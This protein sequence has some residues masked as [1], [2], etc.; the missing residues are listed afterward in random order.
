M[1]TRAES[2]AAVRAAHGLDKIDPSNWTYD[3]RTHY[4]KALATYILANER[5]DAQFKPMIQRIADSEPSPLVD[6]S[7]DWSM[8]GT[9]IVNNAEALNPV[10]SWFASSKWLLPVL[11]VLALAFFFA[12]QLGAGAGNYAA[13]RSRK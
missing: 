5:I 7:F 12:P 9:E 1:S 3:Q 13:A 6:A 4:T 2:I 11:A 10:P 8:F